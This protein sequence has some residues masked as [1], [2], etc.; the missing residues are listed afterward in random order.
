M[1]K[2]FIITMDT[3]GDN[4]WDLEHNCSTR[5]AKYI[6]RFQELAESYGYKPVWLTTYEMAQNEMFVEYMGDCLKRNTCEIGMH[7]H[8]W[9]NPPE[10]KLQR[11]NIY[12]EYLI[13][14][15]E[16]I[17][18][19]KVKVLTDLLQNQ[20]DRKIVSH[21]SGR[22]ALNKKY[23]EILSELGYS[24]DCSVT[25]Y[26]TW[27]SCLGATGL[28]GNDYRNYPDDSFY[29]YKNIM[30]VPVS[31]RIIKCFQ[32]ER[33]DTVKDVAR[34]FKRLFNGYEQWIRPDKKTSFKGIKTLMK[35]LTNEKKEYLMFMLHSSELMPGGSP[36]FPDE[37]SIDKL[38]DNIEKIFE[39]AKIQGYEGITLLDYYQLKSRNC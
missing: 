12:R 30:E 5:N 34:E 2:F 13:E 18:R 15:P 21:R 38:Y 35:I 39:Y 27:E 9:N 3:E 8:A 16:E 28:K 17:I 22:W 11:K 7:L 36:N 20:F 19:E 14:Y 4:Q 25:P 37:Y 6:P 32:T 1:N 31:I 29:I 23:L 26:I 10:Y 24:V 33:V